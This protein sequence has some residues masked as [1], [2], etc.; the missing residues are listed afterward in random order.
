MKKSSLLPILFIIGLMTCLIQVSGGNAW[1]DG[2]AVAG[3]SVIGTPQIYVPSWEPVPP[4]FTEEQKAMQAEAIKRTHLPGPSPPQAGVPEGPIAGAETPGPGQ[5]PQVPGDFVIRR[6]ADFS[7]IVPGGFGSHVL[8]PSA[9][10]EG[11]FVFY[12]ANWF[13]ARSTSAGAVG[14]WSFINPYS[15]FP[16]FCCDQDTAYDPARRA[17]L[18]YRQGI[19]DVNG[20]NIFKLGVS[21]NGGASFCTYDVAPTSV[22]A[23]WTNQWFDY[24]RIA[25]G[26]NYLYIATNMYNVSNVWQR[27]VL[28]RFPLDSLATCSGFSYNYIAVTDRF[29]F[30]PVQGATTVMHWASH[31]STTSMRVYHWSEDT[32]GFTWNDVTIDAWNSGL[33]GHCP[34]TD[35]HN[36]CGRFDYRILSGW[37]SN[38]DA[39][40][41]TYRGEP[42][43]GFFWNVAEGSGFTF[44]YVNA[45]LFRVRDMAYIGRPYI[46]S[47]GAFIYADGAPNARG[48]LGVSLTGVFSGTIYQ[49]LLINDDYNGA[50]P[51]WEAMYPYT[52]TAGVGPSDNVWGDYQRT[53]PHNPAGMQWI[54][55]GWH[56]DTAAGDSHPHYIIYGRERDNKSLNRWLLN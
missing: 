22:N 5:N 26:N 11:M 8:E 48:D 36:P 1:A 28:L 50:P 30:T 45:A 49:A 42:V 14:T 40:A 17:L 4:V 32:T 9:V 37:L 18:W 10:N 3:E 39:T 29:N 12:T 54:A 43:I 7:S 44:P 2:S 51:G 41:N 15:D 27:T 31:I 35:G 46:F 21:S 55:T 47:S 52:S 38:W 6:N 33:P 25:Q 16:S 56:I 23:A 13:A 19:A 34:T 24:P 53:H 20:N